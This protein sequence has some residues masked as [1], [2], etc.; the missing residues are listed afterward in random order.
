MLSNFQFRRS[1]VS[2]I[3]G[4]STLIAILFVAGCTTSGKSAQLAVM[5]TSAS[6]PAGS[7][8]TGAA[9][10]STALT[11]S[12]GTA[13]YTWV[14]TTGSLPTGLNLS[15]GGVISGTP[16]ASGTFPFAVTVTDSATPTPH[17]ATASLSITINGKL[18]V[19]SS[20]TLSTAG[21]AG[22]AYSATISATGGVGPFT[23]AVNSGNLPTGLSL[24]GTTGTGT[25]SGT[26]SSLAAPGSYNFTAKITDSQGGVG[27]SGTITITV[28]AAVAIT[29]PTFPV[30]VVG[31]TYTSPTFAATG[32]SGSGYAYALAS[33]SIAPL[34]LNPNTGVI[35]GTPTSATILQFSVKVTDSLGFTATASSL[36]ITINAAITV[37]LS[38][39]GAVTLDQGKTQL[40]MATVTNDPNSAGVNWSAV[41][42]V[43]TLTGQT[44]A[45]VTYNAP[46]SVT[47]ASAATFTA[48]SKTDPT[49]TVTFTVNLVPPP[50]I[51]TTTMAAGNVNGAYSAPVNMSGGVAPYTWVIVAGPTGLTL[52]SSTTSSVTVQGTPTVAGANQ[53]FTIKV[54][55]AQGLSVTS[56]GLTITIY[57]TLTITPPALSIG[58][59]NVNYAS[60]AFTAAGGSGTGYTFAIASG[61][62]APL[63]IGSASGIISGTPTT[64]ATLHF[65]V[66][67][68]DSV[69]N[70]ATTGQ[71]SITINPAIT[72]A[73]SPTGPVTLDQSKTQLVNVTVSNDPN[74]AGVT[75]SGVTGL[76]TLTGQTITSATYNAP[77]TVTVA[78]VATFTATS[79]TDPS[80]SA[81]FT[82]NLVP[83]PQITTT[84]MAAGNVNGPYSSPVSASGGVAPFTWAILAAPT[85]L[86]LSSSTTSTV[87]VQGAP[88][89]AGANQTFTIKVTD[90]QGLSVTSSGLTITVYAALVLTPPS[91]PL[92]TGAVG[93]N[94]PTTETFTASGGS[95]TGYTWS[96]VAG[97]PLP[98]GLALSSAA[99]ASTSITA[100]PPTAAGTY[101]FTVKL[102]DSV[103]NTATTTGLS[104]TINPPIS[105]ALS[106]TLPFA[107]DQ[108][109]TQLITA[110]VSNDFNSAGVTWSGVTG[111]GSLTGSTSTTI[112]FNAP[113]TIASASISTFTATSVTDPTKSATFTVS[114]EPP[115]VI[116]NPSFPAGTLNAS[117]SSPVTVS[118]GVGPYTWVGTTLPPGLTLSSSTTSTVTVQGAPTTAGASQT[119]TIK[120]TDSKGLT[121]TLNSTITVNAP[122]CSSNCTI[123]GTVT[124]PWVSGVTISISGGSPTTTDASGNYSFTGLAGGTYTIT[125]SLA[126]YSYTPA[127]PLVTTSTSTTTQNF[128]ASSASTAFSISGKISYSGVVT[129]KNTIIRVF[130]SGC[131]NCGALA[132]TSFTTVPSV[133]G[134]SYIVRGLPPAN[135]G[136]GANGSYMVS[137]QIDTVGTGIPN[138]S[139]PEGASGTVNITSSDV[140]G[141]NFTVVD[142][143]PSSPVTPTHVSVAPGNAGAVVQYNDPEDSNSEEIATSYKVYYGTDSNAT[144]GAGSPKTFKAQGH[145]TDI[146]ILKGLANGVTFFKVSAVN[147]KGESAATTPVSVTL[148]AGS[149]ANTVS[150]T[151]TFPGTATGHTLYAGVYGDNGIYFQAITS[152]VSPQAYSF[153]GVPSGTY[154][155]FAILDLNDDGEVNPPD[156][157]D[158]TNHSNPPTITVSGNTTGNITL[159][160]ASSNIGVPT[161]VQGSSGNPN[162]YG[163]GVQV[164]YG[165]KLPIS[166]TLFSG[167]SVAV[168][169]DM[170]AD[171]HNANYNPIYNNSVS[172]T[173]GDTYQFLVTFSDGTTQVVTSTI[174]A[175]IT[176]FAQNLVMQ[177]TS[178]GSP[179][180]PL[181][182]WTAPLTPP[183]A[184]PYTY[185]VNLYNGSGTS[186]EFW[187]Y[188]GSGSGNG[189]PSSQTSVLFD[190][191]GSAN[192]SS[193]L[194]VG[195]TYNWS[196][197]VQ[198][199]NNNSGSFT[200]TYVVP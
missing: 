160:A 118:G 148:A 200:T 155:N 173:V 130:P 99:G 41:T 113:A 181:L 93:V 177:T 40:V 84:T 154:Q 44:T 180:V 170:N 138:E 94:Y 109:T 34:V 169:F 199:N 89:V 12:A 168:P 174:S 102:T 35:S 15:T 192:P 5:T 111:L 43:G 193:S 176:S 145:G 87:T 152:P 28:H 103:G 21:A 4:A 90:A 98:T 22:S 197:F 128:V 33:G 171:S 16:T 54:T 135:G 129:S 24:S 157:T 48:T 86:T 188:Y 73:F 142:R 141:V 108:N 116:A 91:L 195:G 144:N 117:Y 104:I 96:V 120:V 38:P 178:P 110:T 19:T 165:T 149:G 37:A 62:A 134:T 100:G 182:T 42:G 114:L 56:S 52:S 137:A 74:S 85:G 147:V 196:V 146:F 67:V 53:T 83:P 57:P 151:V 81:T 31:L 32:G 20:G 29:P 150:G 58:V 10:P 175:V 82:V 187:S 65:T 97:N 172:P 167:K 80:K 68:T 50:Q 46:A 185:S 194:T 26:I 184:L 69:G 139:N 131:T 119:V 60:P 136:G 161:S 122:S 106:P 164:D 61:S 101:P 179:T 121:N 8:S 112:T 47:V 186:Q 7:A 107:M 6:L 27:I 70:V 3:L 163:I 153:S 124:G 1:S 95:S 49:K 127:A 158:V 159:A 64:A 17:T 126:G 23:W 143:T 9:Y 36:S 63:T 66:K 132:G 189:I 133:S 25:I 77:G 78:S 190:T 198:D 18:T 183:T 166:M 123:S 125:P 191:D 92:P 75:W 105:V 88:T 30:G 59:V 72:V 79:I 156:V 11:A 71:L 39:S 45:A 51:T 2:G 115:P 140:T 14:V 76:G 162:S 55:D 13:P